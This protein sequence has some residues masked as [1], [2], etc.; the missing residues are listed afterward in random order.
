MKR[1]V[2]AALFAFVSVAAFAQQEVVPRYDVF[3]GFS[4]LNTPTVNL[5]QR[6]FDGEAG[7]NVTRW[8][9]LGGDFSAFSGSG[10]VLGGSTTFAPVLIGVLPPGVNP[11]VPFSAT[12]YT[13]AAGPQVEIR[14]WRVI[15]PF[16]RPFAGAIHE[17]AVLAPTP[18]LLPL[19]SALPGLTLDQRDTAPFIG[20]G[21]GFDFAATQHVGLRLAVDYAN[22]H[23]FKNLLTDRRNAVRLSIGPSFHWGQ[24]NK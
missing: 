13:F 4:Y 21:G 10:T 9:S 7:V 22:T 16:V 15:T 6:G 18:V 24:L 23:L 1:L 3:A 8:L 17:H 19:L 11:A 5:N 14:H 2:I 12:T 20:F